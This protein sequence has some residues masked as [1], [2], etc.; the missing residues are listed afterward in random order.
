MSSRPR[1]A[2]ISKTSLILSVIST[3][4]RRQIQRLTD[5]IGVAYIITHAMHSTIKMKQHCIMKQ[6]ANVICSR[7]ITIYQVKRKPKSKLY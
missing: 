4:L 6:C 1:V 2:S 7:P 3:Q 5:K